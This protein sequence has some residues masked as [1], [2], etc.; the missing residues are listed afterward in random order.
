MGAGLRRGYLSRQFG[1]IPAS[2]G[3]VIGVA[4]AARPGDGTDDTAREML[5][6]IAHALMERMPHGGDCETAPVTS[7]RSGEAT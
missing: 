6:D 7:K 3:G 1:V 2:G 5:D 4:I